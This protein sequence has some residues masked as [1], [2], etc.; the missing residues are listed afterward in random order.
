MRADVVRWDLR[1]PRD[2]ANELDGMV[3]AFG[4]RSRTFFLVHALR[5]GAVIVPRGE[6]YQIA[7]ATG[8]KPMPRRREVTRFLNPRRAAAGRANALKR[9]AR[10]RAERAARM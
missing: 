2:L 1:L 9:W 5:R 3:K 7:R 4:F 6:W 10:V 8:G